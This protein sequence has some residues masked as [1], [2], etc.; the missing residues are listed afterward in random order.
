MQ[1]AARRWTSRSPVPVRMSALKATAIRKRL[2]QRLHTLQQLQPKRC[3]KKTAYDAHMVPASSIGLPQDPP[4]EYTAWALPRPSPRAGT[5]SGSITETRQASRQPRQTLRRLAVPKG[6]Q[7]TPGASGY[8]ARLNS[9]R[10]SMARRSENRCLRGI[11]VAI[12]PPFYRLTVWRTYY[13]AGFQAAQS[14]GRQRFS[15]F[16]PWH[17]GCLCADARGSAHPSETRAQDQLS[18]D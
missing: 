10:R 4:S 3:M 11:C 6:V 1:W 12:T 5:D 15:R 9:L 8:R 7:C 16:L 14:G 18:A 13:V 2:H 17:G